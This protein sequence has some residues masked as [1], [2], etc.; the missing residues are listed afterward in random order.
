MVHIQSL[1]ILKRRFQFSDAPCLKIIKGDP[2]GQ[3]NFN[4][5]EVFHV[6]NLLF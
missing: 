4:F 3:E 1:A 5:F 6:S 2:H